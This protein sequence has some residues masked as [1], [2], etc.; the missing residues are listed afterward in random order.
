MSKYEDLDPM[1]KKTYD[2]RFIKTM[3]SIDDLLLRR[4][5]IYDLMEV[6]GDML[7]LIDLLNEM[8][9]YAEELKKE[10]AHE[11]L[12]SWR[13]TNHLKNIGFK[14]EVIKDVM[15]NTYTTLEKMQDGILDE[16]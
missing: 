6:D 1:I 2:K 16:D 5:Y 12:M 11:R 13:L 3:V 15:E 14:E 10:L 8:H 9:E 7:A 4:R